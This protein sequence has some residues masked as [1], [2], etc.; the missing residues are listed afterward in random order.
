MKNSNLISFPKKLSLIL[1]ALDIQQD[2][3]DL[4]KKL[5]ESYML[6][7]SISMSSD[8]KIASYLKDFSSAS[9][10][11]PDKLLEYLDS[12]NVN[13]QEVLV[14]AQ[15]ETLQSFVSELQS[16]LSPEKVEE[17]NKIISEEV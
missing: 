12:K 11:D 15:K 9:D 5:S 14:S 2:S 3:D 4:V 7:F 13:Y 10:A 8:E 17:L 16:S 1:T 6:N